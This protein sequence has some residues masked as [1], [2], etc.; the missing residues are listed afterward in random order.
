M[1]E[2]DAVQSNCNSA[3]RP[4]ESSENNNEFLDTLGKRLFEVLDKALPSFAFTM[5]SSGR[6]ASRLHIDGESSKSEASTVYEDNPLWIQD[7]ARGVKSVIWAVVDIEHKAD[8]YANAV[9]Y[10]CGWAGV[11][12]PKLTRE[13]LAR[14]VSSRRLNEA[15]K[16]YKDA[17]VVSDTGRDAQAVRDYLTSRGWSGPDIVC[18]GLGLVTE[19][20]RALLYTEEEAAK[21]AADPKHPM[22]YVGKYYTLAIPVWAGG[23]VSTF[24]FRNIF[25]KDKKN[26]YRGLADQQR[27]SLG[28]LPLRGQADTVIVVEGELDALHDLSFW[29]QLGENEKRPNHIPVVSTGGGAVTPKQA[30]D[31]VRRGVTYFILAL[32]QDEHK[33]VHTTSS[34]RNIHAAGGVALVVD[35]PRGYKDLDEMYCDLVPTEGGKRAPRHSV[36]DTQRW[37]ETAT[38]YAVWFAHRVLT[39]AMEGKDLGELESYKI[40]RK[41]GKAIME[42]PYEER[43]L[44]VRAIDALR[45]AGL[46]AQALAHETSEETQKNARVSVLRRAADLLAK[47]DQNA[48][49]KALKRLETLNNLA[50]AQEVEAIAVAPQGKAI[51]EAEAPDK[52]AMEMPWRLR[53]QAGSTYPVSIPTEA[54]TVFAAK[55]GHGKTTA[56]L[57]VA[58]RTC[59]KSNG[60][61]LFFTIEKNRR[62]VFGRFVSILAGIYGVSY[63]QAEAEAE[64]V[65][66]ARRLLFFKEGEIGRI[67]AICQAVNKVNPVAC[68]VIDYVQLLQL[69]GHRGNKKERMEEVCLRLR[70]LAIDTGTAVVL[71]AQLNAVT[72]NPVDWSAD[73]IGDAVDIGQ[74]AEETYLLWDAQN[75]PLKGGYAGVSEACQAVEGILHQSGCGSWKFGTKGQLFMQLAKTKT[76]TPLNVSEVFTEEDGGAILKSCKQ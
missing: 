36:Y 42:T 49:E 55:S 34:A 28:C 20:S 5:K 69:Q 1:F 8:T 41:I 23:N 46:D 48:A 37:A 25:A 53:D 54:V 59:Y 68:V 31:A 13:Q 60:S 74:V 73:N 39:P 40:R 66:S 11:D 7:F 3:T 38:P 2:L 47:G 75:K 43:P 65:I 29:R 76:D 14:V 24:K 9:A 21:I 12:V 35:Y 63:E 61:T 70:N 26:R 30:E 71:G 62:R 17:L 45:V 67:A 52:G 32:D 72:P 64:G 6:W 22:H 44:V 16:A 33:E 19:T 57:N 18:S 27:V 50:D 15:Q 10:L 58:A 4:N 51:Y 56:L